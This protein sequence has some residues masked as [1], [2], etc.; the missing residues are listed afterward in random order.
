MTNE[1]S[2]T[3]TLLD[4]NL[5]W[6]CEFKRKN[7]FTLSNSSHV[8]NLNGLFYLWNA[9]FFASELRNLTRKQKKTS[10]SFWC[11]L[12]YNCFSSDWKTLCRVQVYLRREETLQPAQ[13]ALT[14][15]S[16]NEAKIHL[17]TDFLST[18]GHLLNSSGC[19]LTLTSSMDV[20]QVRFTFV[21]FCLW[22]ILPISLFFR[23]I[24]MVAP[25]VF[26]IKTWQVLTTSC[27]VL[28]RVLLRSTHG[29]L[30]LTFSTGILPYRRDRLRSQLRFK[31]LT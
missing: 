5:I 3:S 26:K 30:K 8:W 19:F 9:V 29:I 13:V 22:T 11:G 14:K 15:M 1:G 31:S 16:G 28:L 24:R 27:R 20:I 4:K 21:A 2:A 25:F 7:S 17:K 12:L 23:K 6:K 18:E 10:L